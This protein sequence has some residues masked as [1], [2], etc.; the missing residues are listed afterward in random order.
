VDGERRG[1]KSIRERG[2]IK[3]PLLWWAVIFTVAR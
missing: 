3:Q 1:E 2:G